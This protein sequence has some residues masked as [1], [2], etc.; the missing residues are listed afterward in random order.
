[1]VEEKEWKV[2]FDGNFWGNKKGQRCCKE[3]PVNKEFVWNGERCCVPAMY[4]CSQGI[5]LDFCREVPAE[6]ITAFLGKLM[7]EEGLWIERENPFTWEFHPHIVVNGKEL[8]HGHGS[9]VSWNPILQEKTAGEAQPATDGNQEPFGIVRKRTG[10][11]EEDAVQHYGLNPLQGW[12]IRR[13][14]FPFPNPPT[15]MNIEI[16]LKTQPEEIPGPHFTVEKEGDE[17]SFQHPVW[18]TEHILKVMELSDQKLP[19]EL[20]SQRQRLP[21]LDR[22]LEWPTHFKQLKYTVTPELS[23]EKIRVFDCAGSDAPRRIDDTDGETAGT[24]QSC[25][26][27]ASIGIIGGADG[28]TSIFIAGKSKEPQVYLAFSAMHFERV[29]QVEWRMIFYEKLGEDIEVTF[30]V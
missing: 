12:S 21:F 3:I 2:Y 7:E 29:S 11:P 15:L 24:G 1:M 9:S 13:F 30:S 18:G 28:P 14:A 4:T 6:R 16:Q 26:G 27:A 20:L 19:E 22:H 8:E 25:H 17:V 23:G 10:N 5:V